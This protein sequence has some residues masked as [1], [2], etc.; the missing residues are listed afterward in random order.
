MVPAHLVILSHT[1]FM[2]RLGRVRVGPSR[3]T[4]QRHYLTG[5]TNN[6]TVATKTVPLS[7]PWIRNKIKFIM[8][9]NNSML[10][11]GKKV[12]PK[13]VKLSNRINCYKK[14]QLKLP[15][16]PARPRYRTQNANLNKRVK[17]VQVPFVNR[18]KT[19]PNILLPKMVSYVGR[20]AGQIGKTKRL[21]PRIKTTVTMVNFSSVLIIL[22]CGTPSVDSLTQAAHQALTPKH[23][24]PRP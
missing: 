20:L 17:T 7:Y 5:R 24:Q 1:V 2:L 11:V 6:T 21:R 18:E 22:T 15:F 13:A 4:T 12:V 8:V 10:L 19:M 23:R 3:S 9:N 14:W 16:P